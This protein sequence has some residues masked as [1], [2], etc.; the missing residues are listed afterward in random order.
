MDIGSEQI[1][2][3]IACVSLLIS[4]ALAFLYIRDR[5]HA[6]FTIENDYINQLLQWH[7]SV[8]EILTELRLRRFEGE[9]DEKRFLLIK[10]SASIEKGRFFFPNIK[11][12]DYGLDKPPAYRG[13]RNVGLDFLVASYNLYH[14]S[15]SE[16]LEGQA[17]QLQRLFTSVVYE[18]VRP[19]ERLNTIREL[20][21][22]Y[23]VKGLS[24]EDL[25]EP[26]QLSVV[27]HMWDRPEKST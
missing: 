17:E 2:N 24:V 21:D 15:W 25:Q 14:K 12:E 9:C 11:P 8:V 3:V 13:Y 5:R 6:R 7:H 16:N 18:I 10:L 20:T 27:S 22:R 1:S 4:G 19:D 23:F 26:S